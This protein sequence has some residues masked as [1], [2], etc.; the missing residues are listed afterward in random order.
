[1][2]LEGA[3]SSISYL[4]RDPDGR[5]CAAFDEVLA[6]TGTQVVLTEVRMPRMNAIMES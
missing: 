6:D 1:M 5:S 2:G 3:G 4:I